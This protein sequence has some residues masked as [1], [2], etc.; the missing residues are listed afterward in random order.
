MSAVTEYGVE[1]SVELGIGRQGDSGA[2]DTAKWDTAVWGNPDTTLGD[3]VEVTCDT[4]SPLSLGAGASDAD[5]VVTRWEAA[6]CALVLHGA[7]YDPWSGPWAG[8]LG[9]MVPVRVRWRP[10]GSAEWLAAFTGAIAADGYEW[11]P[12]SRPYATV[13]ATDSTQVLTAYDPVERAAIGAGDTAAER[14]HRILDVAQWPSN[15]RDVTPGGV[16]LKSSTMA[17]AL[18]T[19]LLAVADTDLALLWVR[20]DGR[21]AFR[22][23]GRVG[24]GVELGGKLVV[25][26]P[27]PP[28]PNVPPVASF[29]HTELDLTTTVN[30]AASTDPDGTIVSYAWQFGDGATATGISASHTYATAGTRTVRLTVTDNRGGTGM[31]TRQVTTTPANVGPV[32]VFTHTENEATVTVDGSGSYDTDGTISA[33]AWQFGDG[34]TG[35]GVT[36]AHTYAASGTYTVQL[37]VTDNKGASNSV[38]HAVTV[39]KPVGPPSAGMRTWLR[40]KDLG[41]SGSAVTSWPDHS[42]AGNNGSNI[43]NVT[44]LTGAT[45]SGGKVAALARG[46]IELPR[47]ISS[48]PGELWGVLKAL[49]SDQSFYGF[50]TSGSGS[51]YPYGGGTIYDDF[52]ATVRDSFGATMPVHTQYRIIHVSIAADGTKTWDIDNVR[53]AQWVRA[54]GWRAAPQLLAGDWD[55]WWAECIVRDRV[56][57]PAEAAEFINYF[58]IEHGLAVP[59]SRARAEA[60]AAEPIE[61]QVVTL[62]GAQFADIRNVVSISR[63]KEGEEEEGSTVTVRDEGS[64]SRYLTRAYSRTDLQHR[65]D[66]WSTIVADAVLKSSAW[67][68]QAPREAVLSSRL[69]D[70]EVP[71]ILLSLEADMAFDVEDTSGQIWREACVG[72]AVTVGHKRIEGTI[73]L[74][75]IGKWAGV[76][77]EPLWDSAL[78]DSAL[79]SYAVTA[80]DLLERH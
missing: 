22:P 3:W 68:S 18:W 78:W 28:V 19:Q 47:L 74:L 15:L 36:A 13:A 46:H 60:Q 70:A 80:P 38:S 41:A 12:G 76:G 1:L 54:I 5:G 2:W 7:A 65:D 16:K 64:I 34:G 59:L 29:T 51:H 37:T 43:S 44:V 30:G 32:A 39:V 27:V 33:Y 75:D 52:G 67:P 50:G 10:E 72:W 77:G 79:W 61:V 35:T 45:P 20:R 17:D 11:V 21:V 71:R 24:V 40:G 9:P 4:E 8:I 6:T 62:G 49:P 69:D 58:N 63:Q 55:G 14:V 66:E 23:E 48:G 31:T 53:Q 25:C 26:P 42:G 57:T 56:S 73:E